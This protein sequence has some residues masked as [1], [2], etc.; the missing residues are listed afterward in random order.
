M[1]ALRAFS[2]AIETWHDDAH[3]KIQMATGL[4]MMNPMTNINLGEFWR[5][6]Y[7]IN[8][9]FEQKLKTYRQSASQSIP[10]VI[11]QIESQAHSSVPSI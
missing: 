6:H 10:T 1:A 3:M 7:F 5:L 4:N 2:S 11:T 8:A 9:R